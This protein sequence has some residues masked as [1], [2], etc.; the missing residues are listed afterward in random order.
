VYC[1]NDIKGVG[2]DLKLEAVITCVNYADFLEYT[3]PVNL[4]HFERV[5][6]VTSKA[7]KSTQSVCNRMSVDVV[8]TDMFFDEGDSFNKGHAINLGLAHLRH[9]G[10]LVHLDADVVLPH[11]FRT[12]LRKAKLEKSKIYGA[13]RLNVKSYD[14]WV[15]FGSETVPQFQYKCLVQPNKNFRIGSRLVHNE[16]GYCPIGYFQ[17]WH[18]STQRRY[19]VHQGSAEHT[20][21]LFSV[22]WER[23]DRQLLPEFFVYHL[24]SEESKMGA[25]WKGR[26][27]KKFGKPE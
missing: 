22:Q 2:V 3:L 20:D 12:M 15:K 11:R 1:E 7:D 23:P 18:A 27:T 16:Y 13:D 26:T 9:E 21:V 24:E 19:P 14:D 17:L 5:V 4:P 25:N 10:W 6:V 8:A